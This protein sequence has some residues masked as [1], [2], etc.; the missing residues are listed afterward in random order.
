MY[1]G[2]TSKKQRKEGKSQHDEMPGYEADED[3]AGTVTFS[4]ISTSHFTA[5]V[6]Y[7]LILHHS[8]FSQNDE[9]G[10]S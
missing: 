3:Q 7:Q 6:L 4:L 8:S 9:P 1:F 5:K 10:N 2:S